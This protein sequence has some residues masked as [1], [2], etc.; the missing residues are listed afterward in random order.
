M[1]TIFVEEVKQLVKEQL[2]H[3]ISGEHGKSQQVMYFLGFPIPNVV[4]N[5]VL[6]QKQKNI[7]SSLSDKIIKFEGSLDDQENTKQIISFIN[8]ARV[9]VQA[10][11]EHHKEP[12][13]GGDT[14]SCLTVL[15]RNIDDLHNKIIKLKKEDPK[16]YCFEL[17]NK[18]YEGSALD[19]VA[20]QLI[21]YHG[22]EIFTPQSSDPDIRKN[23]EKALA[24]RIR[25]IN[26]RIQEDTPLQ[27]QKERVQECLDDLRTDNGIISKG[28]D[29]VIKTLMTKVTFFG[30]GLDPALAGSR[31]GRLGSLIDCTE[32]RVARLQAPIPTLERTADKSAPVQAPIPAVESAPVQASI[33]AVENAPVQAPI[34]AVEN[35]PVQAPIPAVES[36]PVQASIS[37]VESA[38]VQASISTT[39]RA[40]NRST[41]SKAPLPKIRKKEPEV[42]SEEIPSPSF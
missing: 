31:E 29:S 1:A 6:A 32:D 39:E 36:A 5:S 9:E 35:A 11:R 42:T 34:P 17:L 25:A 4:Y 33:P 19:I 27:T 28:N 37:A 2:A 18:H 8:T 38:P 40:E 26:E 7:V 22:E 13:D 20:G 21:H 14:I 30:F 15:S 16:L 41:K 12:K 10:A 23:K 3:I 24:T